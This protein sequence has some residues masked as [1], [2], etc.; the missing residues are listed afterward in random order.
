MDAKSYSAELLKIL[1]AHSDQA[2][3]TLNAVDEIL[4]EKV[5]G[6]MLGI[7]PNQEP[8]G[9]FA[10]LI[11]LEGPDLYVLNK[12]IDAH[13]YLFNVKFVDGRLTPQ[14]P[15]FDPFESDIEVN[16]VIVDTALLW[17]EEIWMAFD[18]KMKKIP[19]QVFGEEGYG[20]KTPKRL[21][22]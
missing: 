18:G 19:T 22:A 21:S 11:H 9:M 8:D 14:V 12:A 7:H 13:R 4:P 2:I 6:I 16:D 15:M 10:I 17:L 3:K 1:K 20:T 5:S